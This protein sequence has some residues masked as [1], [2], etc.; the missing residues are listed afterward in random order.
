MSARIFEPGEGVRTVDVGDS[1]VM[2]KADG[3][4]TGDAFA[5]CE[6]TMQ[7]GGFVPPLHL[8]REIAESFYILAGRLDMQVSDDRRIGV[9]G[10][11]VS[12]PTGVPHTM[13]VVGEEPVRMLMVLSN[14]ARSAQ[15]LDTLEQVFSSGDPGS[16]ESGRLLSQ[17]DMEILAPAAS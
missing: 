13:S 1:A 6:T 4:T 10:T 12:I 7:P 16:E 15:M 9:P 5:V 14:P 11:F 3:D 17:L 2:V 8:H